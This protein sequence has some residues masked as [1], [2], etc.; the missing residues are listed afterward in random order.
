MSLDQAGRWH[1][2]LLAEEE[3]AHL[4]AAAAPAVALDLRLSDLAVFSTGEKISSPGHTR[5]E[6]ARLA[7][8]QRALSLKA[9]GFTQPGESSA[10]GGSDPGRGR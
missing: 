4:P 8:A 9:T 10:Q 1:V 2:S 6:T 7:R 3:I 5:R